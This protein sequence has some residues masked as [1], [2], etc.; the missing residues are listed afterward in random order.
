M[1]RPVQ[2]TSSY[3]E[4]QNVTCGITQVKHRTSGCLY[5]PSPAPPPGDLTPT[6][7]AI[8]IFKKAPILTGKRNCWQRSMARRCFIFLYLS[9]SSPGNQDHTA[10]SCTISTADSMTGEASGWDLLTSPL[11]AVKYILE[12]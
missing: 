9:F 2:M 3:L 11:N 7:P 6:L 12:T 8:V 4:F 10:L 1:I 5:L